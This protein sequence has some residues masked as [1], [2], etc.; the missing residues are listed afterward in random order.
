VIDITSPILEVRQDARVRGSLPQKD[1]HHEDDH[2]GASVVAFRVD[3]LY[4]DLGTCLRTPPNNLGAGGSFTFSPHLV[5]AT[6]APLVGARTGHHPRI[7]M[8]N[9]GAERQALGLELLVSD[10]ATLELE[11]D[12]QAGL[13][14]QPARA[15]VAGTAPV[16]FASPGI[17]SHLFTRALRLIRAATKQRGV[18]IICYFCKLPR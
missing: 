4:L 3:G 11:V 16:A 5:G 17:N 1:N 14:R 6:A 18:A 8:G 13:L 9:V 7:A 10:A 15:G 12:R 2:S